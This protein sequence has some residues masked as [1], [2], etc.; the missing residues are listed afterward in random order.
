MNAKKCLNVCE[1]KF[2][3]WFIRLFVIHS[4]FFDSCQTQVIFGVWRLYI[5]SLIEKKVTSK[6]TNP[7]GKS[8]KLCVNNKFVLIFL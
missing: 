5:V 1:Q 6:S 3:N 4:L 7:R 2:D 8:G